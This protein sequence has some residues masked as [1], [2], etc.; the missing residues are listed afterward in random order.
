MRS[1]FIFR[2]FKTR[3]GRL[4]ESFHE[5]KNFTCGEGG[6]LVMNDPALVERAEIIREK[7]TD[8]SRFSRG[9][10]T[11]YSWIDLAS[12]DVMSDLLAALPRKPQ[13]AQGFAVATNRRPRQMGPSSFLSSSDFGGKQK[14]VD[15]L[16]QDKF[17][18]LGYLD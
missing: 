16:M 17:R 10:V 18:A 14:K 15:R 9:E 1:I 7:G 3:I 5:T 4:G 12:S 2:Q 8:R 11:K 13:L 6:A